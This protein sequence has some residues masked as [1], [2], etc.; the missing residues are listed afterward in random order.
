MSIL[1]ICSMAFMTL[2]DFSSSLSCNITPKADGMICQ[3]SP[4]LS[5]SQPHLC[6]SPPAE[7]LSQNSSTSSCVSQSTK[8]DIAGEKV[9]SGPPLKAMNSCPSSSNVADMTEP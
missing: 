3:A 8:N 9:K 1:S 6:F 4:Y 7:S 5:L 2:S